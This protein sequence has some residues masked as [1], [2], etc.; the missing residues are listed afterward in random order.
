MWNGADCNQLIGLNEA[1]KHVV[2]VH[3]MRITSV[4][5]FWIHKQWTGR[6][7]DRSIWLVKLLAVHPYAVPLVCAQFERKRQK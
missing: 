1:N 3:E 6:E 2:F 5:A 7:Y 4:R